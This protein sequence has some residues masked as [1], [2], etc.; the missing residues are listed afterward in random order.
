MP[1]LVELRKQAAAK[2]LEAQALQDKADSEKR[3]V[4]AEEEKTIFE[5]LDQ[6]KKLRAEADRR[7]ILA[8]QKA[9]L[10]QVEPRPVGHPPSLTDP[11]RIPPNPPAEARDRAAEKRF[12]FAHMGEFALAVRAAMNPSQAVRDNR[13]DYFAAA[14]GMNLKIGSEGGFL[15]PP[16]FSTAIWDG[17]N[18]GTQSLLALTDNY[19]V[20]G[21]DS[22]TFNANAE[23][24]RTTGN[25]YGG[26]RGY[27][28]GEAD[29]MTAS[30]PKLRQIRIEPQQLY[31][32]AFVTDRLLRNS[33]ISLEQ[34]LTRAAID[35]I[36]FLVSDAIIRGTGAG[37]PKGLLLSGGLVTVSK[38]SSQ[39]NGTVLEANLAKMWSRLH[40]R[41]RPNAVWFINSDVEPPLDMLFTPVKNNAGSENVGGF[42]APIYDRQA[43]TIKGRPV[44]P[45]EWCASLGT[46]GDIIL[47]DMKY[48][49]TGTRGGVDSAMSIHLRF[50]YNETCFRFIFEV[51]GQPW[52][53]TAITPAQGSNTQ[54]PFVVLE[55][56]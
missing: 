7:Q 48:Y 40:P 55:A 50:D 15:L 42:A 39:A 38:E 26:I 1:S 3:P 22:L 34:Y 54:S 37:Q 10:D 29:Q 2:I 32:F 9:M 17:L 6:A 56:R 43:R 20:E 4:T 19:T 8:D 52:L 41:A 44:V 14:S 45:I 11:E 24:N 46:L 12:G 49:V 28:K 30:K 51:D 31:V 25:R 47:A 33:S 35:E 53:D 5:S 18:S 21:A 36:N 13:L 27:W 23:T 16:A